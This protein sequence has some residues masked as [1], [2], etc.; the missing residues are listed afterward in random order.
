LLRPF[1]KIVG[2]IH[3]APWTGWEMDV[4]KKLEGKTPFDN[5]LSDSIQEREFR[6]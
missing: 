4:E 5:Q 1:S 2:I 6:N 3:V